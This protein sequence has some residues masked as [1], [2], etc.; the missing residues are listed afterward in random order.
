MSRLGGLDVQIFK[1]DYKNID[2]KF[3]VRKSAI[4]W[5]S[6]AKEWDIILLPELADRSEFKLRLDRL[7]QKIDKENL[8]KI[9]T[10]F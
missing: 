6:I 7:I 9:S 1:E 8:T 3:V 4:A 10:P 2:W 5:K